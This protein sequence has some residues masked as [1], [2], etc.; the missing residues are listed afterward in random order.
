MESG[1]IL[2]FCEVNMLKLYVKMS[3][4]WLP[5]FCWIDFETIITCEEDLTKALP[6]LDKNLQKDLEFFKETFPNHEF[7]IIDIAL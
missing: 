4:K 5:V 1:Y 3:N 6:N 7:K 2:E